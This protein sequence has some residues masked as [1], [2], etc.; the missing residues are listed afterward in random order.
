MVYFNEHEVGRAIR[1]KIADGVVKREDIFY[2]GK[3]K[4]LLFTKFCNY[5]LYSSWLVSAWK[6][7][8]A[9]YVLFSLLFSFAVKCC[10]AVSS[11]ALEYFSSSRVGET[12]PGEDTKVLETRLCGSLHRGAPYGL[13]GEHWVHA[14]IKAKTKS[15][16]V[17]PVTVLVHVW[18]HL[19]L[20]FQYCSYFQPGTDFYPKDKDGKYIYHHTDLCATWEVSPVGFKIEIHKEAVIFV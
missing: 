2:C 5:Y 14:N 7:T 8:P 15:F 19:L 11:S 13:Q 3:V 20:K 4:H 17:S 16:T 10:S 1:E 12:N 6:I 9:S 18:W